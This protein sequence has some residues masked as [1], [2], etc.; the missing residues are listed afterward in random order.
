MHDLCHVSWVELVPYRFCTAPQNGSLGSR[1]SVPD[2]K[3]SDRQGSS[4]EEPPSIYCI[5]KSILALPFSMFYFLAHGM[6][7]RITF[8]SFPKM[9]FGVRY[10]ARHDRNLRN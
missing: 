4:V 2:V 5:S 8:S 9:G 3:H 6:V 10:R 1:S 7:P